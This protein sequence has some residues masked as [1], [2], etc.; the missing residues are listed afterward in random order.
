[1][2]NRNAGQVIEFL[3]T[4][5]SPVTQEE[6]KGSGHSSGSHTQNYVTGNGSNQGTDQGIVP[7]I[8]QVNI[9][10]LGDAREQQGEVYNQADG[11]D[12]EADVGGK[13][14]CSSGRPAHINDVAGNASVGYHSL[15]HL[16]EG[17]PHQANDEV[18]AY[19]SYTN[20]HC[21]PEGPSNFCAKDHGKKEDEH[22]KQYRGAQGIN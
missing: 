6:H 22:R 5:G 10:G 8:P 2:G 18:N 1:V 13:S 19:E 7:E 17:S 12:P 21:S 9:E 14:H 3:N 20:G 16:S 11:N 15:G 4:F